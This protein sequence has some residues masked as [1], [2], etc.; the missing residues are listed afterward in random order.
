LL[1]MGLDCTSC[2]TAKW[3][4]AGYGITDI[5]DK[6]VA[7]TGFFEGYLCSNREES[8]LEALLRMNSSVNNSWCGRRGVEQLVLSGRSEVMAKGK[9]SWSVREAPCHVNVLSLS[10]STLLSAY[11]HCSC[12]G[13]RPYQGPVVVGWAATLDLLETAAIGLK[14]CL[15][16]SPSTGQERTWPQCAARVAG[17]A[18]ASAG[19]RAEGRRLVGPL[20]FTRACPLMAMSKVWQ[21]RRTTSEDVGLWG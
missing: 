1:P 10:R 8:L 18:S 21:V 17:H 13:P 12:S 20:D 7:G 15:N 6:C 4:G 9:C 14:C 19:A 2:T 11:T 16:P 3:Q 5:P